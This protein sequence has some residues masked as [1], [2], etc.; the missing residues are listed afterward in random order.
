M[1]EIGQVLSGLSN[2][3]RSITGASRFLLDHI[4]QWPAFLKSNIIP[5]FHSASHEH[6]VTLFYLLDAT[7]QSSTKELDAAANAITTHLLPHLPAIFRLLAQSESLSEGK[8]FRVIDGWKKKRVFTESAV[9]AAL[10]ESKRP[11]GVVQAH[12]SAQ[13]TN[14]P[15]LL[16]VRALYNVTPQTQNELPLT[17]NEVLDVFKKIDDNWY[18]GRSSSGAVGIFPI[19]YVEATA[20]PPLPLP[21]QSAKVQTP[22]IPSVFKY[23]QQLTRSERYVPSLPSEREAWEYNKRP[24]GSVNV[25]TLRNVYIFDLDETLIMFNKLLIGMSGSQ[26]DAAPLDEEVGKAIGRY[27]EACIFEIAD[28]K[29]FMNDLEDCGDMTFIPTMTKHDDGAPLQSY[30]FD[31]GIRQAQGP[32]KLK[33]TAYRFRSICEHYNEVRGKVHDEFFS[34]R[35]THVVNSTVTTTTGLTLNAGQ[36]VIVTG[37]RGDSSCNIFDW[38]SGRH[39]FVARSNLSPL[40]PQPAF[41]PYQQAIVE[42]G[43]LSDQHLASFAGAHGDLGVFTSDWLAAGKRVLRTILSNPQ[44]HVVLVTTTHLVATL[45]KLILFQLAEFFSVHDIYSARVSGKPEC[46]RAIQ[47]NF[48][49]QVRYVA[50]GDGPEEESASRQ[51]GVPFIKIQSLDDLHALA[52][53]LDLADG[54]L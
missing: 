27:F 5:A 9:D 28:H 24:R 16:Q 45:A 17:F 44:C 12:A 30:S 25:S 18:F 6:R 52:V 51:L 53:D 37:N 50:V 22:L 46:F 20:S 33:K 40:E 31:D 21:P 48:G 41:T 2:S 35:A 54:L 14:M 10:E 15:V 38:E 23:K 26:R 42:A 32:V 13:P 7:C 29:F 3:Q 43:L 36:N 47:Q 49:S 39:D 11:L 1:E 8:I 4:P 34:S 19:S